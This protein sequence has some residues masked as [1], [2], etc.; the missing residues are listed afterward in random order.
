MIRARLF[1]AGA[2]LGGVLAAACNEPGSSPTLGTNSN[3]FSACTEDGDCSAATSC[4]CA[5]CTRTC[6]ADADCHGLDDAHCAQGTE[7]A[8]R[9]QCWS[10]ATPAG[11]CLPRCTPGACPEDE[12]CVGGSC[13]ASALPDDAFCAP[14]S[15]PS[16]PDRTR[17]DELFELVQ[18]MRAAGGITCGTNAPSVPASIALAA[19]APLRCAARVF[20]ADLDTTGAQSLV[21]SSGR[22]TEQRLRAAGY[23]PKL[24]GESFAFSASSA[25]DAL[26]IMLEGQSACVALTQDGYTDLGVAHVGGVYVATLGGE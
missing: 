8:T 13:V 9:S 26:A 17:E 22:S 14:A 10:D 23:V 7:P 11:I 18:A 6:D 5:R 3:W 4:R 21:D 24:W 25:S 2:L 12:A 1:A 20:A 15:A 19:S 16:A